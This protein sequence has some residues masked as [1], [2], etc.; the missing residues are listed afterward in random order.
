LRRVLKLLSAIKKLRTLKHR[1]LLIHGANDAYLIYDNKYYSPIINTLKKKLDIENI[2]SAILMYGANRN[3]KKVFECNLIIDIFFQLQRLRLTRKTVWTLFLIIASP[4][5]VIS[6]DFDEALNAA[7]KK[8]RIKNFYV[9]H[10]VICED[11]M[12]FG[13][14]IIKNID[15]AKLPSGFL[16]WDDQSARNFDTVIESFVIGNIWLNRLLFEKDARTE[17]LNTRMALFIR[18]FKNQY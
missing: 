4:K 3:D 16:S 9:Q 10:G 5:L 6:I 11:H 8:K 2:N 15:G 12:Y 7:C 13:N 1:T 14:K 17:D 18:K